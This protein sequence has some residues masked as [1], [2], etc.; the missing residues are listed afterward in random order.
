MDMLSLCFTE[1]NCNFFK[2]MVF[3]V[4]TLLIWR[5]SS[6]ANISEK[7][8]FSV[9]IINLYHSQYGLCLEERGKRLFRTVGVYVLS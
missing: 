6:P 3:W 8:A 1:I 7:S 2:D 4:V 9:L 5:K